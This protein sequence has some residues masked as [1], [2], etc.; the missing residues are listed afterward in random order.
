MR[1]PC[2]E[3]AFR[4]LALASQDFGDLISEVSGALA[5]GSI[6]DNEI[7][8]IKRKAG[9]LIASLHALQVT[10]ATHNAAGRPA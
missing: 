10:L 9:G 1:L 5:D 3:Y 4:G 2:D 6:S 8:R 7:V